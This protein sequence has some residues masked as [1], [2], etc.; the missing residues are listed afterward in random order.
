[1]FCS[2]QKTNECLPTWQPL[3]ILFIRYARRFY[4]R[5]CTSIICMSSS[6]KTRYGAMVVLLGYARHEYK[7]IH[8]FRSTC[9]RRIAYMTQF[10]FI[11]VF[12]IQKITTLAHLNKLTD[13]STKRL[14]NGKKIKYKNCK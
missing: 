11:G 7:Y 1:M 6:Y 14:V 5:V 12:G 2:A 9:P 3:N 4:A 13:N 10:K 8:S